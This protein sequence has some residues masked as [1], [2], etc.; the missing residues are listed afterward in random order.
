MVRA[1]TATVA[2]R[3]AA[4]IR[5]RSMTA[6]VSRRPRSRR[7]SATGSRILIDQGVE[8]AAEARALDSRRG[9]KRRHHVRGRNELPPRKRSKLADRHP[10]ARHD[11]GL[12]AIQR[13]HDLAAAV[14][15]LTLGDGLCHASL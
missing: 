14:A 4:S 6:E 8:V 3:E 9:A 1:E 15:Q 2:G 11:K 10:V 13:P 12:S 7:A 5:S